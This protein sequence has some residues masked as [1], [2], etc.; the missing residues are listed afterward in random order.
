MALLDVSA[1]LLDPDF[2]DE[3]ILIKR[4]YEVNIFG[5]TVLREFPHPIYASIQQAD[6]K[7]LDRMPE[8]ARFQ[9]MI[10][11]LYAGELAVQRE[12]GF[13]DVILW[14]GLRYQ[15]HDVE[16]DFTNYG[17][18]YCEALCLIEKPRV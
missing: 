16:A 6:Y 1:I 15:V 13:G 9:D 7:V 8:G 10:V 3:A 11:V 2:L 4:K 5:E 14:Q 18:G 17:R 12:G